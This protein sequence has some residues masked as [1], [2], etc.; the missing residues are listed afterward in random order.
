MNTVCD[1]VQRWPGSRLIVG[2]HDYIFRWAQPSKTRHPEM[3]V[4]KRRLR[5]ELNTAQLCGS[6]QYVWI[7]ASGV[8]LQRNLNKL[9]WRISWTS[10][11]ETTASLVPIRIR[12]FRE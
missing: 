6:N 7:E 5:H 8:I 9:T 1:T 2:N 3:V 10:G 12:Y 11:T 4:S